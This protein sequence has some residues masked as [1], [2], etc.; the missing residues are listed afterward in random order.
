[1]KEAKIALASLAAGSIAIGLVAFI[2]VDRFAFTRGPQAKAE[3]QAV[4]PPRQRQTGLASPDTPVELPPI[5]IMAPPRAAQNQPR[6]DSP[7]SLPSQ[8]CSEW[9]E[10]GPATVVDGKAS[11]ARRVRDLC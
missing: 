3:V 1:M 10:I 8:P 6:D 11:G 4:S 5:H 7:R 2:Q 9:R